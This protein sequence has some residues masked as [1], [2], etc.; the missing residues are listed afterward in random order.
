MGASS[1]LQLR[2]LHINVWVNEC[3]STNTE[4]FQPWQQELQYPVLLE[5]GLSRHCIHCSFLHFCW[6]GLQSYQAMLI[7]TSM[8]HGKLVS[9]SDAG[10]RISFARVRKLS[11]H[12]RHNKLSL[13]YLC[14]PNELSMGG[15]NSRLPSSSSGDENFSTG[16]T[17]GPGSALPAAAMEVVAA[18]LTRS[19]AQCLWG[20]AEPDTWNHWVG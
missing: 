8:Q 5:Q 20:A 7:Q 17:M 18:N 15:Q 9:I 6:A 2:V 1:R 19:L 14:F 10:S 13:K 16:S 12:I 4:R 11:A 3:L